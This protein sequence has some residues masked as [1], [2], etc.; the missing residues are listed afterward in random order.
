MKRAHASQNEKGNGY[1]A[2]QRHSGAVGKHAAAIHAM[3]QLASKIPIWL[4]L[5][6]LSIYK[7]HRIAGRIELGSELDAEIRGGRRTAL[8]NAFVGPGL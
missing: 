6:S 2:G 5:E 4:S 1:Y 3:K 8:H 7:H